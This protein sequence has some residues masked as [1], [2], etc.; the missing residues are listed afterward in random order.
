MGICSSSSMQPPLPEAAAAASASASTWYVQEPRPYGG[1]L[2][3]GSVQFVPSKSKAPGAVRICIPD[4]N[5]PVPAGLTYFPGRGMR[6]REERDGRA[7]TESSEAS[8][9][10]NNLNRWRS[11]EQAADA[12]AITTRVALDHQ[13]L[14]IRDTRKILATMMD[15]AGRREVERHLAWLT[16]G[17][18]LLRED[19]AHAEESLQSAKACVENRS[20]DNCLGYIC[21]CI[22]VELL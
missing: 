16:R 11:I 17:Q 20:V 6:V 14:A 1:N 8:A 12:D 22:I 19:V 18:R 21:I 7:Q 9:L 2:V 5:S 3:F 15:G 13:E 10:L 4:P